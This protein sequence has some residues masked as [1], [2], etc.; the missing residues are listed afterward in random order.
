MDPFSLH[1]VVDPFA[2]LGGG[3][4]GDSMEQVLS[5]QTLESGVGT[6]P[7]CARTDTCRICT[8]QT[9]TCNT[10]GCSFS[11]AAQGGGTVLA[12]STETCPGGW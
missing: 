1:Q 4:P 10:I 8:E 5:L 12:T 7:V 3:M 2:G 9:T 6:D 11:C